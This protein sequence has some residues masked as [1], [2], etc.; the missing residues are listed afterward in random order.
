[1]GVS[2]SQKQYVCNIILEGKYYT[3]KKPKKT[4]IINR[5]LCC[6]FRNLLYIIQFTNS[7]QIY[8]GCA[9]SLYNSVSLHKSNIK[10]L[11]HRKTLRIK[12]AL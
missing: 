8:I 5:N 3:F 12:V 4:F 11:D 7:K 6:N 10:L 2:E 9:Q 1:M